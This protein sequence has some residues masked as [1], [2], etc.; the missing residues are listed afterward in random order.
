MFG[1]GSAQVERYKFGGSEAP[2][3]IKDPHSKIE[4]LRMKV[5]DRRSKT[6]PHSLT[7]PWACWPGEFYHYPH[8]CG[9]EYWCVLAGIGRYW[10]VQVRRGGSSMQWDVFGKQSLECRIR[11][12]M[13][14]TWHGGAGLQ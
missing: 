13:S 11:I 7:R 9:K 12:R 6:V 4:D 14:G 2:Q 10:S 1:R 8:P 5:E 3:R